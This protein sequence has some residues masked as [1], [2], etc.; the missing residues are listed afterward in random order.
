MV[1]PQLLAFGVLGVAVAVVLHQQQVTQYVENT[2]DD[3]SNTINDMV[4][5]HITKRT[6]KRNTSDTPIDSYDGDIDMNTESSNSHTHHTV[7][8]RNIGNN[9]D[10]ICKLCYDHPVNSVYLPCGRS[11]TCTACNNKLQYNLSVRHVFNQLP[12][13]CSFCNQNIQSI[14]RIY[15]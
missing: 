3:I 15:R 10:N 13:N 7:R 2:F 4:V 14:H 6:N 1:W 11:K 9:N 12:L 8:Q 5:Q